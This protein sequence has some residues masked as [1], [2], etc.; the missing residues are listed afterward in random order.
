MGACRVFRSSLRLSVF[1]LAIFLL[2]PTSQAAK[3][4]A[5]IIGVQNYKHLQPLANPVRDA[6]ATAGLLSKNGFL[7]HTLINVNHESFEAGLT[8][9]KKIAA[10]AEE[11]I[12]L[13]SGHGMTV[14]K[15]RR[16]INALTATDS[17]ID[18]QTRTSERM[19]TMKQVLATIANVPK[20]VLLFD[21]CRNDA[22]RDCESTPLTEQFSGFQQISTK[23]IRTLAGQT[24]SSI[25]RGFKPINDNHIQPANTS[26]LI[27]YSTGLGQT[28]LDGPDGGNSPFAEALL[29]ELK[30]SPKSPIRNVLERTSKRVAAAAGQRPWVVTDG[31]EPEICLRGTDCETASAL[32][33]KE[34]AQESLRL[35]RISKQQT[36]AESPTTGALLALEGLNGV[37]LP[38]RPRVPQADAALLQALHSQRESIILH[39]DG[40]E[41][42]AVKWS[43]DGSRIATGAEDGSVVIWDNTDGRRLLRLEQDGSVYDIEWSPDA[44]YLAT[45][46]PDG[47]VLVWRMADGRVERKYAAKDLGLVLDFDWSPKGSTIVLGGDK[48]RIWNAETGQV[49][50]DIAQNGYSVSWS[51]PGGQLLVG[52]W[53]G[54]TH[55]YNASTG[56]LIRTFG[57]SFPGHGKAVI[58][59]AWSPDSSH[60][61][62]G[63][64]D[65]VARIWN[66]AS[67]KLVTYLDNHE[68]RDVS[69]EHYVT[70][71]GWSPNGEFVLT[72][73]RDGTAQITR[74]VNGKVIRVFRPSEVNFVTAEI[75]CGGWHPSK[76]VIAICARRHV[77]VSAMEPLKG[78]M[79]WS[80]RLE[81]ALGNDVNMLFWADRDRLL[82][83]GRRDGKI[84]IFN[85]EDGGQAGLLSA[86]KE[87]FEYFFG[88]KRKVQLGVERKSAVYSRLTGFNG[89]ISPDEKLVAE[90]VEA[91]GVRLRHVQSNKI[92][93]LLLPKASISAVSWSPNSQ[94]L[95]LGTL[96]SD[97]IL[98]SL[99]SNTIARSLKRFDSDREIQNVAWSPDGL[100]LLSASRLGPI[101]I[102]DAKTGE[103]S[104]SLKHRGETPKAQWS[105]NG[106]LV[107]A[108]FSN[109]QDSFYLWDSISGA[110]IFRARRWGRYGDNYLAW[111]QDG[112]SLATVGFRGI[113]VWNVFPD[114]EAMVTAARHRLPRCLTPA[115]RSRF[116]L[117]RTPP[118]WCITGPGLVADSVASKWVAKWPYH[119]AAWRNWLIQKDAGKS[120]PLPK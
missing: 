65:T 79:R 50:R 40:S 46:G 53:D 94:Q 118:R 19:V 31:G 98:Y 58:S 12:I 32:K 77:R 68:T 41:V 87:I 102:W 48:I 106:R 82:F 103:L 83:A 35:A 91:G 73:S 11:A 71:T 117:D 28:A 90:V 13:Y 114:L 5:L 59:V 101:R 36:S 2:I 109:A 6:R 74:W 99:R 4:V 15:D 67:G 64:R 86:K 1:C 62:T 16:L 17:A 107:A 81:K 21:A 43:P 55:I 78:A 66:V 45:L 57:E 29:D 104:L 93:R 97:L 44:K 111:S 56:A 37:G 60:V 63:S 42:T 51:P 110:E 75:F 38:R 49:V 18:C 27:G 70:V 7:V 30:A 23:D 39:H 84:Q 96:D 61:I 10:D 115:E 34:L 113:R 20:Q 116:F 72:G 105:P 95:F 100:R 76:L 8:E 54:H 119:T 80:K 9:F 120:V 14:V 89:K 25:K 92:L 112:R 24:R 22:I 85:R 3:R 47:L 88:R 26:I 33:N 69:L 108:T 52:G